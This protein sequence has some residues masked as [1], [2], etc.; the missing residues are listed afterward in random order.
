MFSKTEKDRYQ[1][2]ATTPNHHN[3]YSL[4]DFDFTKK[5]AFVFGAE[6]EGV[7]DSVMEYAD[8]FL[9]IPMV[10]FTESLN[11]SVAAAIILESVTTRLR[12]SKLDWKLSDEEMMSLYQ[13]WIEKSIKNVDNIKEYYWKEKIREVNRSSLKY[14]RGVYFLISGL[15]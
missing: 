9:K 12:N 10:G 14:P 7:S 4:H 11:I 6:K 1:I 2:I 15:F 5:S 3:S 13:E 8:G